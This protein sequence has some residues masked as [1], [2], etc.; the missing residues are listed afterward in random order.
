MASI[1]WMIV[2]V[3]GGREPYGR[4]GP[5]VGDIVKAPPY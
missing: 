5:A 3:A 2:A 4:S 1:S